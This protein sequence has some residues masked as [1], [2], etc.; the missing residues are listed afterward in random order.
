MVLWC[1]KI[2]ADSSIVSVP[3]PVIVAG[4]RQVMLG[5]ENLFMLVGPNLIGQQIM[6]FILS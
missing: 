6:L 3:Q 5:V 4:S 2:S 1:E